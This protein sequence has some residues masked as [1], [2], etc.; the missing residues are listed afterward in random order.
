M[1]SEEAGAEDLTQHKTVVEATVNK[2]TRTSTSTADL[3]E[4]DLEV[5]TVL[6]PD[7]IVSVA[8]VSRTTEMSTLTT[9]SLGN[10]SNDIILRTAKGTD[11]NEK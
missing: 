3:E 4:E 5:E 2:T 11:R 9:H 1:D 6:T 10:E 8:I 7:K